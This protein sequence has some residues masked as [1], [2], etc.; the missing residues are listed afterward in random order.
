MTSSPPE[1]LTNH[2]LTN[3]FV[4]EGGGGELINGLFTINTKR[5]QYCRVC[6]CMLI[7]QFILEQEYL[8][9]V[10]T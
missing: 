5:R 2:H 1:A 9:Y 8:S 3:T 10:L 4:L 7:T 6:A